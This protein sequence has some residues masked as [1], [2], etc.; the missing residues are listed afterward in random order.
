MLYC[1]IS[2]TVHII[3]L[4]LNHI[5]T[6]TLNLVFKIVLIYIKKSFLI[7][8]HIFASLPLP[9]GTFYLLIV[10]RLSFIDISF[11]IQEPRVGGLVALG[12]ACTPLRD[13]AGNP[14]ILTLSVTDHGT[15]PN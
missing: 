15:K 4:T 7:C 11:L 14:V 5:I 6:L 3:T 2:H 1:L 13:T 12:G 8:V 9:L 10:F